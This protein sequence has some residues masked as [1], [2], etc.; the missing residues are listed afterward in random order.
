MDWQDVTT[1]QIF[2]ELTRRYH[3]VALVGVPK[4][5]DQQLFLAGAKN[6]IDELMAEFIAGRFSIGFI[7]APGGSRVPAL[8]PITQLPADPEKQVVPL[9][10]ALARTYGEMIICGIPRSDPNTDKFSVFVQPFPEAASDSE[11]RNLL[12]IRDRINGM[13]LPKPSGD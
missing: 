8:K 12:R 3:H 2:E 4:S 13:P 11:R 10:Q 1:E 7:K 6:K 5:S 9:I